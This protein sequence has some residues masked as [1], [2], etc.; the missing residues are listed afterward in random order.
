MR[1]RAQTPPGRTRRKRP[2]AAPARRRRHDGPPAPLRGGSRTTTSP[3]P[4]ERSQRS[5]R[6]FTTTCTSG[7]R[8][9]AGG[10]DRPRGPTRPRSPYDRRAAPA[11]R[12]TTRHRCTGRGIRSPSRIE[13]SSADDRARADPPRRGAPARTRRQATASRGR[14]PCSVTRVRVRRRRRHARSPVLLTSTVTSAVRRPRPRHQ[15]RRRRRRSTAMRQSP[16]GSTSCDRW[17]RKPARPSA[18]VGEPHPGPP[19]Q[20]VDVT[21][22]WSRRRPVA[23]DAGE[24][25]SCSA[26]YGALEPALLVERRR[27]ASRS[28]RTGPGRPSGTAASPAPAPRRR[29]S[30]AS[31]AGRL[32][33]SSVTCTRTR[34][35]GRAW[36]TNTTRPSGACADAD[37]AVRRPARRRAI[38]RAGSSS[39]A[40]SSRR[41]PRLDA[42]LVR[43]ARHHHA[44]REQQP[45]LEPQ[46]ALVVQQLLP[47][48]ADDVLRDVAPSR[49]RAGSADGCCLH[50]VDDR[51][52]DLAV[53]RVEDLQRHRDARARPTPPAAPAVSPGSTSTVTASSV[54]RPGRAGVGDGAQRRLVHL[55][56]QHDG[57]L[58]RR[59]ASSPRRSGAS[60]CATRCRSAGGCRASSGTARAIATTAIQAP[61]VNFV[62][63][64][65]TS[66]SAGHDA[67]PNALMTRDRCICR[68]GRR[69]GLGR[70]G[71]GSS[72]GPCRS[73]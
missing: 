34:S 27:A 14:R 50:V 48:V 9:C 51:P 42:Q 29:T 37:A 36:R 8:G 52:G 58:A 3:A 7:R 45:A 44:G 19:A 18:S 46:R 28:R 53:R 1:R 6:S 21:R 72:A 62:T 54:V 30:T 16:T 23:V 60:S 10:A 11:H 47:P 35:P 66:T 2:H 43:H 33:R 68:R 56:D 70:A 69:V 61:S 13:A 59:A 49:R 63:S 31:R 22:H 5:T 25:R 20:P 32:R 26:H 55:G 65:M 71:A 41:A 12:R 38:E 39:G 24:P 15:I 4:A 57:V 67:A 40:S 73:G 64:T 17:R